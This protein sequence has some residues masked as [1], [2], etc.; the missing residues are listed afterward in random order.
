MREY[1]ALLDEYS[2]KEY[3]MHSRRVSYD[4]WGDMPT[5]EK[6]LENYWMSAEEY[7]NVWRP[8]Q[9]SIFMNECDGLPALMFQEQYN[10]IAMLGGVLFVEEG[11]GMLQNCMRAVGNQSFAV[12]Q[13]EYCGKL[14]EV[15]FRLRFPVDITWKELTGG[16]F[17]S[18]ILLEMSHNDYFVFAETSSWGKYVSNDY[19]S[20]VDLIGFLPEVADVFRRNFRIGDEKLREAL[21]WLSPNY[22]RYMP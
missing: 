4:E 20:E 8:I 17:I 9:T 11:F 13:H 16:N 6:Y 18:A 21:G 19:R 12:V 1:Q 3:S 15:P 7:A 22:D 14:R 5:A 2:A 10:V